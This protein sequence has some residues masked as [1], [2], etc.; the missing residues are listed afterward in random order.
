[1]SP[2]RCMLNSSIGITWGNLSEFHN[3]REISFLRKPNYGT[4]GAKM[5]IC[6]HLTISTTCSASL[7]TKSWSHARLSNTSHTGY[8]VVGCEGLG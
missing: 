7:D 1:M 2:V 6:L 8:L 4:V 5:F 3:E